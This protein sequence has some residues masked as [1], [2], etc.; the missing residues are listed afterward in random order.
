MDH[1]NQL[2]LEGNIIIP[3]YKDVGEHDWSEEIGR[4]LEADR[5]LQC[6]FADRWQLASELR[7]HLYDMQ[8]IDA[9]PSA[10]GDIDGVELLSSRFMVPAS[11]IAKTQIGLSAVL[12]ADQ[13]RILPYGGHDAIK[14]TATELAWE[15]S[16]L[17]VH[18]AAVQ[19]PGMISG[20]T[21]GYGVLWQENMVPSSEFVT[22]PRDG[23]YW[24]GT[25]V[26][27]PP[28]RRWIGTESTPGFQLRYWEWQVTRRM[29]PLNYPGQLTVLTN[30]VNSEAIISPV[31]QIEFPAGTLL[32]ES[33]TIEE[34]R[35][36]DGTPA[37]ALTMHLKGRNANWNWSPNA[38][39][40]GV[41]LPLFQP[42]YL[43]HG[44]HATGADQLVNYQSVDLDVL[45]NW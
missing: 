2:Q 30:C 35:Q 12:Y 9:D 22:I 11:H 5:V 39:N 8:R 43:E 7:G 20:Y 40:P 23:L 15:K 25:D 3:T 10:F 26:G 24:D 4:T 13:V 16:Q 45:F 32:Y 6:D 37:L 21:P 38:Q 31:Y 14:E 44:N 33:L 34:D 27:D 19:D 36:P 41:G 17:H 18:Y 29:A 1:W 28:G 42:I